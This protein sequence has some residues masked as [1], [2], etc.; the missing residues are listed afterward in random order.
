MVEA[1]TIDYSRPPLGELSASKL[2]A[3]VA[4]IGDLAERHYLEVKGARF[5]I[6]SKKDKRKIAK[7]ILGAANRDPEI[8]E[9][10]FQGYAVMILGVDK[11]NIAGVEPTEMMELQKVIGP[12]LGASGPK[13]DVVRVPVDD[14]EKE[15]LVILVDPP[16]F[17][18]PPFPCRAD[19]EELK[20]G[21]I[22]I[23]ADGDTREA[24]A[25]EI[26]MLLQRF[27]RVSPDVELEI[28]ITGS[29]NSIRCDRAR[30]LDAYIEDKEAALLA[31]MP[32]ENPAVSSKLYA[33]I[34]SV[35]MLDPLAT[36]EDRTR[37]AYR[38]EIEKWKDKSAQSWGKLLDN[39]AALFDVNT[40]RIENLTTTFLRKVE[41]KIHLSGAVRA[42]SH[43]DLKTTMEAGPAGLGLPSSPRPWGPKKR[44]YGYASSLSSLDPS[45]LIF[46]PSSVSWNNA[47]S[48][49]IT[50]DV[51]DLRPRQVFE[52]EDAD[53]VLVV[54]DDFIAKEI[55]GTWTATADGINELF[56]GELVVPVNPVQ[57]MTNA[58]RVLLGL[59]DI[60][61]T[62]DKKGEEG[63]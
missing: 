20:N 25:D 38:A 31:A 55:S 18:Q 46:S 62:E 58:V 19:G 42:V 48:G 52:T 11:G 8:A 45:S 32:S 36:P 61:E 15:V 6:S 26:D 54:P 21:A 63:Q 13:W 7:F 16:K 9:R 24:K 30:T 29:I 57:D 53:T 33:S 23:R 5:D 60:P 27:K 44:V 1:E 28:G 37:E 59:D 49:D 4:E 22:Y 39:V 47:G 12:F 43:K 17:G 41:V 40:I 51:G 50:V 14:S 56:S 2:I 3:E 10:Y 34:L 35:P